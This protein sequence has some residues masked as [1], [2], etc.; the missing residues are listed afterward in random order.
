VRDINTVLLTFRILLPQCQLISCNCDWAVSDLLDYLV[1][2]ASCRMV[3]FDMTTLKINELLKHYSLI[4]S[5]IV[6]DPL[7][8]FTVLHKCWRFS[9]SIFIR[10]S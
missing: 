7:G 4:C 6:I 5:P 2:S 3:D 8:L 10:V 1:S 9:P